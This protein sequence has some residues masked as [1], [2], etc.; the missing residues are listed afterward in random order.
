MFI[1]LLKKNSLLFAFFFAIMASA[2]SPDLEMTAAGSTAGNGPATTTVVNLTKNANNPAGSTYT[3]YSIGGGIAVTYTLQ[4]FNP[5]YQGTTASGGNSISMGQ[6]GATTGPIYESFTFGAPSN[7]FFT[8][9]GGATAGTGIITNGTA[10]TNNYGVNFKAYTSKLFTN[11]VPRNGRV[12]LAELKVQFSRA[13]N[14][15]IL[16]IT[17]LGGALGTNGFSAEFTVNTTLSNP[18]TGINRLSG[19]PAFG[20]T[21]LNINNIAALFDASGVGM[22]AGSV[23][24]IGTN[25]TTLVFDV[26]MH[27]DGSG[28]VTT[29]GDGS[30]GNT[31]GDAFVIA[32]TAS[33]SDLSVSKTVDNATPT[34]GGNV[35]FTV[36]AKNNGASNNTGVSVQDQLPSG[37]TYVSHVAS[38][39][40][41]IPGTG[42]W[43]IGSLADQATATLAITATVN[44]T[45]NYLNKAD[46][47]TTSGLID[48]VSTNNTSSISVTPRASV[49]KTGCNDNTY[50]NSIDPNTI[51]YDN[52]VGVFHSSMVK[53][54]DGKIKVW[55]QGIAFDGTGSSGNVLVPQELNATNY[56]GL[57]GSILKF[58]AGSDVNEQQFAVLTTTGLFIWGGSTGSLVSPTIKP[59]NIF[60]AVAIGTFGGVGTKA[61]GLPT[62][63]SPTDVK[64]MFGTKNT[65]AIVTC[66]GQA[67]ILSTSGN[68][69]GDGSAENAINSAVWHRV[70]TDATTDLNNVIAVRGTVNAMM[71][72]TSDG[73]IY[74]WGTNTYNGSVGPVSR[75]FATLMTKPAGITP[76]MIG[77]TRSTGGVS[78]YL[79]ATN[80]NLYS[81]GKNDSRQLGIFSTTDSNVWVRVQQS[82]TA[83][84]FLAD[85]VWISP[86]EHEGGN[87][88]AIN[89]LINITG[90]LL[91]MGK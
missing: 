68:K 4:N 90:K 89:V 69:Y 31:S 77:M 38:A 80:G 48:P 78:Y 12:K 44:A 20:V 82:A 27:G 55:G 17:G 56:P 36:I 22:A 7:N 11:N 37:Y 58:A 28:D 15:P 5:A 86:Q 16:Q 34:I 23:R 49:C 81:L 52:M 40:T 61:D 72:L 66:T 73:N 54:A 42:V 74:T 67:W 65:L 43:N 39:G 53:E 51:E 41:F 30:D 46:I 50:V 83:G 88:A 6:T 19:N 87:Y 25:I 91:G 59:T 33:E 60:G 75:P 63:V 29:W 13:V 32:L 71:A 10:V 85:V 84:D 21:G 26:Y 45:G 76:K 62:G 79:L 47:S 57:T 2:Q 14:N 8:S 1:K 9:S 35:V 24:I 18:I 3:P 70:K 64:M